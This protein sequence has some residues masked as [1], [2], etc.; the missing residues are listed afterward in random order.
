MM[1][2]CMHMVCYCLY[3]SNTKTNTNTIPLYNVYACVVCYRWCITLTIQVY[4]G[5]QLHPQLTH[6]LHSTVYGMNEWIHSFTCTSALHCN[7]SSLVFLSLFIFFFFFTFYTSY[8]LLFSLYD[9]GKWFNWCVQLC[10]WITN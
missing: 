6:S 3:F 8:L 10:L 9:F 1:F 2:V 7:A 4:N 5:K